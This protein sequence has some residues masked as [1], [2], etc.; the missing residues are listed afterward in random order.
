MFLKRIE[1]EGLSHYSYMVGDGADLAVIDPMRDIGVYMREARKAGMR[2]KHIFE[3]HRNED[4][5]IGS[6]EL[7][8][9]TGAKVYISAHEELGHV[10]GERIQDGFSIKLG[11]ITIKALHTPGHTLGH[12]S[13]AVYEDG[14]AKPYLIFTGDCLFMGIWEERIFM[15]NENLAKN[16][17]SDV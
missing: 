1:T 7:Q 17:R 12:M 16:D 5:V 8:A 15:V 14:K 4:Y 6:I 3:T 10:Y 11:S 13:Y 9:K 2:I